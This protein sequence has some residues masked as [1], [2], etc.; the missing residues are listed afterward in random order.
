MKRILITG[1]SGMLGA[2][3]CSTLQDKFDIYSY[4]KFPS[5]SSKGLDITNSDEVDL[6][7]ASV[8]PHV[9][10]NCAAFT[11]VDKAEVNKA[12]SR[13]VNVVGL[14]NILKSCSKDVKI[15]HI[16]TDYIFDGLK[17]NYLE[18]SI[19]NPLNYY[20]RTKLEAENYLVG[21]NLNY[22]ILRPNVLYGNNLESLNFFSWVMNSLSANKNINIV[23]DQLSNPVYIPDLAR[24]IQDSIL[25]DYSGI[26]HFGSEDILSRY[27]F[28]M[29]ICN[30]FSLNK[31]LVTAV[32]TSSL[33]QIANRPL[34]TSLNCSKIESDLNI[35]LYP[36]SYS[37]ER[38][39][40][41]L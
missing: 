12:E 17:G 15:I 33:N 29:K 40:T 28:A 38:I 2:E 11:N 41:L 25:L 21:S 20:G 4:E 3:L 1:A 35:N 39:K 6:V 23:D 16:S 18:S 7:I 27:D 24:V 5:H 14:M 34:N 10:I 26:S 31:K 22:L 32:K 37:L 9:I 19:K 8:K 30:Y 36:T 13:E